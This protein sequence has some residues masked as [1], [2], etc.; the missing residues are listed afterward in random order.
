MLHQV[1]DN[2][3]AKPINDNLMYPVSDDKESTKKLFLRNMKS[4]CVSA[5][6]DFTEFES[7]C[8]EAF[9]ELDEGVE[10]PRIKFLEGQQVTIK[11]KTEK[12]DTTGELNNVIDRYV[13]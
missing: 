12:N 3:D 13:A 4:F 1:N 8:R 10:K 9:T 11:V 6:I 7:S 5:G 2:E